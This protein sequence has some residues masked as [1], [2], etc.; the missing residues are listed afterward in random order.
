MGWYG[1]ANATPG[2]QAA[3]VLPFLEIFLQFFVST[4]SYS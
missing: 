2:Q 4:L 1:V 3:G